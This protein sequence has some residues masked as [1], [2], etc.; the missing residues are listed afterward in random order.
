MQLVSFVLLA[1]TPAIAAGVP[2]VRRLVEQ[3]M[4]LPQAC[5]EKCPDAGAALASILNS[6]QNMTSQAPGAVDMAMAAV[7]KDM[8]GSMFDGMCNSRAAFACLEANADVCAPSSPSSPAGGSPLQ[9]ITAGGAPL[10]SMLAGMPSQ[11]G[12]LCDACPSVRQAYVDLVAAMMG[13]VGSGSLGN[14]SSPTA[15]AT[16]D[17]DA[18]YQTLCPFIQV[19]PCLTANEQ[20]KAMV[21]KSSSVLTDPQTLSLAMGMCSRLGFTTA[22]A[23]TTTTGSAGARTTTVGNAGN[24]FVPISFS[25]E[26]WRLPIQALSVATAAFLLVA[27]Q[28]DA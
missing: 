7:M 9:A 6:T 27:S 8:M 5:S 21:Q 25:G 17:P 16:A 10:A 22:P 2:D 20:C 26:M 3:S 15:T 4:A 28:P 19:V 13:G 23:A 14:M 11:L 12:C 24:G 18:L 1:A